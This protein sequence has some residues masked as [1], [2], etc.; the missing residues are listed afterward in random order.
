[1]TVEMQPE[2]HRAV[3]NAVNMVNLHSGETSVRLRFR[4][5]NREPELDFVAN[6]ASLTKG[7]FEFTAGFETYTGSF[8]D[9]AEIHAELIGR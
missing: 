5:D 8:E 3:A 7:G 4:S 6:S 1:M 9:L 2:M